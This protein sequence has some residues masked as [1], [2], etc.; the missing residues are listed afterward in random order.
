MP[1]AAVSYEAAAV[2][3]PE[4]LPEVLLSLAAAEE[5]E[6]TALD[7]EPETP[8]VKAPEPEVEAVDDAAA[9][10]VIVVPGTV[11]VGPGT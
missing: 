7:T 5:P 3:V 8:L 11:L 9:F 10:P 4:A 2:E 1:A 6:A